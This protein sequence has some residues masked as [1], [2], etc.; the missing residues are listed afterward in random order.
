MKELHKIWDK[1][2][3]VTPATERKGLMLN[4]ELQAEIWR[5]QLRNKHKD[6][7]AKVLLQKLNAKYPKLPDGDLRFIAI[8]VI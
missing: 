2:F 8:K 3:G 7:V 4:A 5:N 1:G 6:T